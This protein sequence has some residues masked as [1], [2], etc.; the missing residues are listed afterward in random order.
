MINEL[1]QK[2]DTF[3]PYLIEEGLLNFIKE[4]LIFIKNRIEI[5]RI[6]RQIKSLHKSCTLEE[7]ISFIFNVERF[8][9]SIAQV[10]A[11]IYNVLKF[12]NNIE[13]NNVLEIGTKGGGTL[14]LLTL[15]SSQNSKIIS[16][17]LPLDKHGAG[18]PDWKL[19]IYKSFARPRQKMFFIRSDSHKEST[20]KEVEKALQSSRCDLL[21]IDGDH[22]Y[23]GVKM[24][25]EMYSPLVKS[26]GYILFHDIAKHP[27]F[28]VREFWN[29]IKSNYTYKEFVKDWN[30]G[31]YGLGIIKID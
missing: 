22:T 17:D 8:F 2:K 12:L 10:K 13:L 20:K 1:L 7:L 16:I 21:L 5:F 15:I 3:L 29:E 19:P 6:K 18:Y 23:E 4:I 30:Q 25:F 27:I 28:K 26:G 14:F 9:I 24:D 11:E 31:G